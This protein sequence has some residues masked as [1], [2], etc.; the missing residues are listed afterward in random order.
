MQYAPQTVVRQSTVSESHLH[1]VQFTG[2]SLHEQIRSALREF[3]ET[4]E[5]RRHVE[6]C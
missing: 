6:H 3:L 4:A 5:D 2:Q 1:P